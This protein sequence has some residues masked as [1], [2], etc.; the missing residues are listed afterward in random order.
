LT[1]INTDHL[2]SWLDDYLQREA[3]DGLIIGE[4]KR[5]HGLP[6][7]IEASILS[8]IEK[9]K[10]KHPELRIERQ[11]ERFTSRLARRAMVEG[12]MKASRRKKNDKIDEISAVIILQSWMDRVQR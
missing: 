3:V 12:G 7:D 1:T 11:D 9:I 2:L 8:W 10:I 6:S 5:M 4:P